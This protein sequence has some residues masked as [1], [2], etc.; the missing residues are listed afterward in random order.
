MRDLRA[1]WEH[2]IDILATQERGRKGVP[3]LIIC[4]KG[5]SI[6]MELKVEGEQPTKLQRLKLEQH[7]IAGGLSMHV[8]PSTWPFQRAVLK[9]CFK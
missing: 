4:L 1:D 9:D 7:H 2:H 3:D 5:R 6:K 8:M